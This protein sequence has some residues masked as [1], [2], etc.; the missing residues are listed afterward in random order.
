MPVAIAWAITRSVAAAAEASAAARCASSRASSSVVGSGFA[1]A[2]DLDDDA[3]VLG[4]VL[5]LGG[6]GAHRLLVTGGLGGTADQLLR[7]ALVQLAE[8]G[9]VAASPPGAWGRRARHIGA[10]ERA[11]QG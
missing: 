5:D 8:L 2:L 1:P 11:A 3:V 6:L 10:N 9:G 4:L 7:L